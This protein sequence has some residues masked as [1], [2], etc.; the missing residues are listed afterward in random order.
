MDEAKLSLNVGLAWPEVE[1]LYAVGYRGQTAGRIWFA[2]DRRDQATPW[3]WHLCLPLT[4]PDDTQG[5]AGSKGE[6]LQMLANSLHTL[7]LDVP[8]DRIERALQLS[9]ATGLGFTSG[10]RVELSV[11]EIKRPVVLTPEQAQAAQ[12]E[13]LAAA[14]QAIAAPEPPAAPPSDAA[15]APPS[16]AAPGPRVISKQVNV[17]RKRMSVVKVTSGTFE[18]PAQQTAAPAVAPSGQPPA[19]KA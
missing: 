12:A 6:A 11:A 7:L 16:A 19:P 4:L 14:A 9:A 5:S 15:A 17:V 8:P 3:E 1:H 10:D 2:T 18:R 13:V